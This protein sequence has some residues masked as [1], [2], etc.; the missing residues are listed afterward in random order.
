MEDYQITEARNRA[1][2][3][4][5]RKRERGEEVKSSKKRK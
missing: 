4:G 3:D 2:L 1:R 5:E